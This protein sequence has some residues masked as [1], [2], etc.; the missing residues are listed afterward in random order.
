MYK[1][2][3]RPECPHARKEPVAYEDDEQRLLREDPCLARDCACHC[4]AHSRYEIQSRSRVAVPLWVS[5]HLLNKIIGQKQQASRPIHWTK[6]RG[7]QES[8]EGNVENEK[9]NAIEQ[10]SQ[11]P[12]QYGAPLP[13]RIW[14]A[15]R[16]MSCRTFGTSSTPDIPV[17]FV[18][19]MVCFRDGSLHADR[20]SPVVGQR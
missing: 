5:P 6:R 16:A 2:D 14:H 8:K 7:Y 17:H 18:A 4:C 9:K 15:E 13:L 12:R 10:R 11:T 3:G 20:C 1:Y 19:R